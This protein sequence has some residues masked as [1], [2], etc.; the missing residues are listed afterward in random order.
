VFAYDERTFILRQNMSVHH[1]APFLFVFIGAD[2][3]VLIDAGATADER[4][5]PLRATVDGLVGDRE[6]LVL[7]THSHGDHVAGDG[8]F[9]D[10]ARTTVVGTG[11]PD[12]IAFFGFERWP[13]EVAYHDRE[14]GLLLTGDTV[15][16]GRLYVRDWSAYEATIA[17]LVGFAGSHHVSH[18][19]GC[20]IEMS[21]TPRVDHPIRTTHHPDEPPLEMTVDQLHDVQRAV[22]TIGGRPGIHTFDDFIIFNGIPDGY[23][24]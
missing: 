22:R 18:V 11:L 20:H 19:L 10:R 23:F 1:E 13:H 21:R 9:E 15:Y 4:S 3:A 7:H 24:S 17:R 14:T 6:L 5:F 2:R 16:P 8:Q 12:V